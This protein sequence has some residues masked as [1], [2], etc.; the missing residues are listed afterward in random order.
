MDSLAAFGFDADDVNSASKAIQAIHEQS[1][2]LLIT[3]ILMPDR[4]GLELINYILDNEVD[5][6]TIAMS[7]GGKIQAE[8]Y[9]MIADGLEVDRTLKKPFLEEELIALLNE[10]GIKPSP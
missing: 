7:G 2:A 8:N 4:D 9:L 5:L 1:Y 6:K 10:L 3:D